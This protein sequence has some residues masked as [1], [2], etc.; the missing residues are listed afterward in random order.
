VGK[1]WNIA[2][3]GGGPAGLAAALTAHRLG[4][5]VTLFE[6]AP[7]F[8]HIGGGILLHSNG[9]RALEAL[10]LLDSLLPVLRCSQQ[11]RLECA[12][13]R[14]LASLD[15]RTL[16]TPPHFGAALMRYT[17]QDHLCAAMVRAGISLRYAHTLTD[18]RQA[19]DSVHLFFTNGFEGEFDL[20]IGADGI[21]S[22]VRRLSGLGGEERL[23]PTPWLRGTAPLATQDDAI[24]EIWGDDGRAFGIL[25]LLGDET[26]LFCEA[27]PAEEWAR[28]CQDKEALAAWV[29]SWS[30]WGEEVQ[31]LV[32]S[33]P[34]WSRVYWSRPGLV[35]LPHWH[36]GRVF[37]IGDAAHALPPNMGQGANTAMVDA[38][39]LVR[40]LAETES[41]AIAGQRY[42]AIR[43]FT[44][45]RTQIAAQGLS[46]LAH[47]KTPFTRVLRNGL[48]AS[49]SRIPPLFRE[50]VALTAGYHRA[51]APYLRPL[52]APP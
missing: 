52:P 9:L 39:V 27:P 3:I 18:I 45:G 50:T 29:E 48:L 47:Q 46:L 8:E 34:D 6:Q 11:M 14:V 49:H 13:G 38:L 44:V 22:A 26:H 51:D 1:Q 19:K 2:V 4:F 10:D 16:P 31:N 36:D 17:L 42:E 5:A 7:S 25:P 33:V 24:R 35:R 28:L 43:R 37:L 40:L 30:P 15:Y 41:L 23:L 12:G 21:H 20:V 32:H